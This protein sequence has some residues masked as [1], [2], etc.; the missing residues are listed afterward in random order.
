MS[1]PITANFILSDNSY[2]I[3]AFDTQKGLITEF[4]EKEN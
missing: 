4:N 3:G 2:S 1:K